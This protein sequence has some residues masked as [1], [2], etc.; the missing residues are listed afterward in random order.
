ME[1][2]KYHITFYQG[3]NRTN[4]Q[5]TNIPTDIKLVSINNLGYINLQV[6]QNDKVNYFLH[7]VDNKIAYYLFF[8]ILNGVPLWQCNFTIRP[9]D[10]MNHSIFDVHFIIEPL[11]ISKFIE[12]S[13][14]LN[15]IIGTVY[16]KF[17]NFN[18][19]NNKK[20]FVSYNSPTNPLSS[21]KV[22]LYD[23]QKKSLSKMIDMENNNKMIK[24]EYSKEIN[25]HDNYILF[26]PIKHA[27]T[28]DK[29]YFNITIKGG[30][31]ADE[32]GLGKTITSLALISTNKSKNQCKLKYS[33][34]TKNYKIYSKATIILC[35]SHLI[36]QWKSEAIKCD[37]TFKI[38]TIM[39]KKDHE[40]LVFEDFI[41]A[42]III[43]SHQF[44]MNFKYYPCLYYRKITPSMYRSLA[45]TIEI[46]KYLNENI[47]LNQYNTY[48]QDEII[49]V[50]TS[51]FN[52]IKS[53]SIPIFEFFYFHRLILDEGHEIFG[54]MLSNISLSKYM[55][56]WLN[57]LDINYYWYVSGSPFINYNGVLNCSKFINLKL[58]TDNDISINF[59]ESNFSPTL[60]NNL[61]A[62][63]YLWNNILEQICIRHT[64]IDVS[65][66]INLH[67]YNEHIEWV[68]FTEI[69]RKIYESKK[70]KS[71]YYLLQLCCHPLIIESS[72]K[73][74][75]NGNI[76]LS[77]MQDKLISY[78]KEHMFKYE[79]KISKLLPTN[80]AYHM[81]KKTYENQISE[82][83]YILSILEKMSDIDQ[84][85]ESDKNC[86][87]C[88]ENIENGSVTKCGH[89]FCSACI[90]QC[91]KYQKLCPMCKKSLEYDEI[92]SIDKKKNDNTTIINC[93]PLIQKYGSKLGKIISMISSIILQDDSRIIIFSQ[94]DTMLMLIAKALSENGI[95]NSFI[96]GNVWSRNG[97][98][99]T[100]RNGKTLSGQEN[101]VIMLSLKNSASGTNL[102][103]ATHIF[104]VEPINTNK[105]ERKAIEGQAIGRACR[106]GQK[107]KI[108][109]YRILVKNTIEE[110]IYNIVYKDNPPSQLENDNIIDV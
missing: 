84:I 28:N 4:N 71:D 89:L 38:I 74:F 109:L 107:H 42:D 81:I 99:N 58:Y 59:N 102:T 43:T 52:D 79:E 30:V 20:S 90:K 29:K 8:E 7:N 16:D 106:L 2:Y 101:K 41:N 105:E 61:L 46:N 64:K 44:L 96:K 14:A 53:I 98:I 47:L 1:I 48:T 54:E 66:E 50:N 11:L 51:T 55:S 36:M 12:S 72:R 21:F 17:E 26:D 87:I 24:I 27:K 32:M 63:E 78:H 19:F 108:D 23:Y 70:D 110:E 91:L 39:T 92:Y 18:K 31:L 76:D 5:D 85:E 103:E 49:F 25:F 45:R 75:G 80:Q 40:K 10:Y 6:T 9:N 56:E 100:F 35:P 57:Q 68:E 95:A 15:L 65:Q 62:K 94:W 88:L 97:A 83:K 93:N 69:E 60:F 73:I 82:S 33:A 34:K 13:L 37:P 77:V 67:G 22:R 104:F 3:S 86:S